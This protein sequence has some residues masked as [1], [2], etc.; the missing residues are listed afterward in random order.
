MKEHHLERRI[1]LFFACS[2]DFD[3]VDIRPQ[4]LFWITEIS[5][6]DFHSNSHYMEGCGVKSNCGFYS[7]YVC[8]KVL[9]YARI[10]LKPHINKLLKHV[11]NIWEMFL[12]C[13]ITSIFT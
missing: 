13:Y 1:R 9:Y 2:V 3:S 12:L 10:L 7:V 11:G 4:L 6:D 5:I 8:F